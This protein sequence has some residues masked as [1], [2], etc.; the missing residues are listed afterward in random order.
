MKACRA[1][2]PDDRLTLEHFERPPDDE[3]R[4]ERGRIARERPP[5]FEHGRRGGDVLAGS[6]LPVRE[7]FE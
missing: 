5:R 3:R 6:R 4:T 7:I 1:R 2:S